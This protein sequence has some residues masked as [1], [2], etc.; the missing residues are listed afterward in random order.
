VFATIVS[1]LIVGGLLF[2]WLRQTSIVKWRWA[3]GGRQ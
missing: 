3:I 2:A 1:I